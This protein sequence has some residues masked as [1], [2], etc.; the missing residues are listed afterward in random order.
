MKIFLAMM[1]RIKKP[2]T[3]VNDVQIHSERVLS[4]CSVGRV[5]RADRS[6]VPTLGSPFVSA[7]VGNARDRPVAVTITF[8][9]TRMRSD[10]ERQKRALCFVCD[11]GAS[12]EDV[13]LVFDV[14]LIQIPQPLISIPPP[15]FSAHSDPDPAQ[16][17][18]A[19]SSR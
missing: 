17:Y 7:A 10:L 11:R 12:H 5:L 3:Y 14:L 19:V 4:C 8:E 13:V 9:C 15:I 2:R 1:A 16:P 6:S 18:L